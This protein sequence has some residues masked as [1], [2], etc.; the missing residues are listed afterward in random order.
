MTSSALPS[1]KTGQRPSGSPTQPGRAWHHVVAGAGALAAVASFAA[2]SVPLPIFEAFDGNSIVAVAAF[3]AAWA[4]GAWVIG[5]AR[6][7]ARPVFAW[8]IPFG[9]LFALAELAGVS[10]LRGEADLALLLHPSAWAAVHLLG[11][12]YA[13]TMLVALVLLLADRGDEDRGAEG[14]EPT[15]GRLAILGRGRGRDRWILVA[16]TFGATLLARVPYLAVW[17]PGLIFFDTY[18][19]LSYARGIMPWDAYEPVGHSLLIAGWNGVWQFFGWS[20]ATALAV[21]STV[22]LLSSTAAFTF[23]L[24]RLAAWGVERRVWGFALAWVA[25]V[26]VLSLS[27]IT[28]VKD[29][30]FMSAFLVLAVTIVDLSRG[31]RTQRAAP[32]M[33][34]TLAISAIAVAV[35][36]SNGVYVVLL[37]LP[38]LFIP[39][40]HEWKRLL[41]A[42]AAVVVAIAAY[43]GP[44]AAA[45]GVGPG[46]KTEMWSIPL[47][48]IARIALDHHDELSAEDRAFVDSIFTTWTVDE[49]GEHYIPQF[50][51]PIK[52]D[53]REKWEDTTTTEFLGGWARLVG[54]Y[55]VS[56]V[57][58]TLGNTVGYW[59]PGAPS[60]DGLVAESHNDVRTISLDIPDRDDERTGVQRYLHE[61]GLV[62]YF[63]TTA[64]LDVPVLGQAMSPGTVTW[65]W[66]LTLMIV[67]RRRTWRRLALYIPIGVLML[68]FLAGPVSGG[69]RYMLVFVAALPIAV[70]LASLGRRGAE[71]PTAGAGDRDDETGVPGRLV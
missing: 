17:W 71:D 25:L 63:N 53:A 66:L 19:S 56:A 31:A 10:L 37:A 30:P 62:G 12:A 32:W 59:A 70:G 65:A 67:V 1:R 57:V 41:L 8:A 16:A 60:Y 2:G 42:S 55:P 45:M 29:I 48:Q 27:S 50:A 4:G 52:L 34:W 11:V 58:A 21:A 15:R 64:S 5:S 47:Q 38:L 40:R 23:V 13:A 26:P 6:R 68:T 28:V 9:I 51:D 3:V 46:P 33:W 7:S 54:E 35:L 24:V 36:R 49:V 43:L 14:L 61:N 20:D 22:Q 44:L 39:L 69:M 18:R